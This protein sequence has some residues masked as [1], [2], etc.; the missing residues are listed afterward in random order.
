MQYVAFTFKG[1]PC[2]EIGY[3]KHIRHRNVSAVAGGDSTRICL[4]Y[5]SILSACSLSLHSY[6]SKL[7]SPSAEY[8]ITIAI[9]ELV[10]FARTLEFW[11]FLSSQSVGLDM[12]ICVL[13]YEP[14]A[15]ASW[16][17]IVLVPSKCINRYSHMFFHSLL[18]LPIFTLFG[19]IFYRHNFGVQILIA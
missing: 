11:V 4:L 12:T 19:L 6:L 7:H 14:L 8:I 16:Q 2:C 18:E 3:S 5:A 10:S 9:Y 13:F 17:F 1:H 15:H